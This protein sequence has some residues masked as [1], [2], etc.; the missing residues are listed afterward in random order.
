MASRGTTW[1][2]D[3]KQ[4]ALAFF[5]A[6]SRYELF[7]P[8]LA[9]EII[10]LARTT[11][12]IYARLG[13]FHNLD[14]KGIEV[15]GPGQ[16]HYSSSCMLTGSTLSGLLFPGPVPSKEGSEACYTCFECE[17]EV[18]FFYD[19]YPS[20]KEK[21]PR[22]VP[23]RG[24]CGRTMCGECYVEGDSYCFLCVVNRDSDLDSDGRNPKRKWEWW[25]DE[26]E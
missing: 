5:V 4:H 11:I 24:G 6:G 10:E 15:T 26:Y 23:C 21:L 1:T 3:S 16:Y 7:E 18:A 22:G 19:A 9:L 20:T 13:R 25:E 12:T 14:A 8:K 17:C 2:P